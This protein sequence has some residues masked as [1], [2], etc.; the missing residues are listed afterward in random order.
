MRF[1]ADTPAAALALAPLAPPRSASLDALSPSLQAAW[2]R[3]SPQP[4]DPFWLAELDYAQGGDAERT[5]LVV[6]RAPMSQ[7]VAL[8]E[9]LRA[10]DALP[11]DLTCLALEGEGFRGQRARTWQALRG[12]LH[13]VR[14]ARLDLPVEAVQAA[15]AALPAVASVAALER[16]SNGAISVGVKWVN[17]LMV[18]EHKVGGVLAATQVAAGIVSHALFGIGINLSARPTLERDPRVAPAGCLSGLCGDAAPT[19]ATLAP[20]LSVELDRAVEG[21]RAGAAAQ[22]L[23]A[24][25][26]ASASV[27]RRVAVWPVG[28]DALPLVPMRSGR[29]LAIDDDLALVLDDGSVVHSGRITFLDGDRDDTRA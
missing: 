2:S 27:G 12:N 15:L 18:A 22:L 14:L 17:D 26:R 21:L 24:Y 13:L 10:G 25:R 20:A 3:L 28:D 5:L 23:E 1:V 11:N 16:A 8:Q 4:A 6:E 29:V 19:L 9:A 7:F